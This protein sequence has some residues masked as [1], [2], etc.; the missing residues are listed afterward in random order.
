MAFQEVRVWQA[1]ALSFRRPLLLCFQQMFQ[2]LSVLPFQPGW[3]VPP[4]VQ[5]ELVEE[6]LHAAEVQAHAD[7]QE[8]KMA[9]LPAKEKV[10]EKGKEKDSP[11]RPTDSD[12]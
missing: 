12:R 11:S 3:S 8:E 7:L 4:A 6:L 2:L 1:G 10:K 9:V 5:T